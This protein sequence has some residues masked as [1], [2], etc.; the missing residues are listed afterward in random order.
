[1]WLELLIQPSS[2][3][4]TI[5]GEDHAESALALFVNGSKDLGT[6]Y[7]RPELAGTK[8]SRCASEN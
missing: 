4:S 7:A 6:L 3:A 5:G 2:I 1:M 8:N